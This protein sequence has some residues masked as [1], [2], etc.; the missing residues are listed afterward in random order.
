MESLLEASV[1]CL[2]ALTLMSHSLAYSYFIKGISLCAK[3]SYVINQQPLNSPDN[4]HLLTGTPDTS[5]TLSPTGMRKEDVA[6]YCWWYGPVS[7]DHL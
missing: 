6:H 4:N 7:L 1:I 3:G 2:L 5:H